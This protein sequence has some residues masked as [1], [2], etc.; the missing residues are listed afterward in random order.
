MGWVYLGAAIVLEVAA[1]LCLKYSESLSRLWPSIAL[2]ILYVLCFLAMIKALEYLQL[3]AMYAVWGGV[4]T[5]LVAL[6]SWW[7]FHDPMSAMKIAGISL[8][9]VGVFMTNL[10]GLANPDRD[11]PPEHPAPAATD[12]PLAGLP[13]PPLST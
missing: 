3:G 8:I 2:F 7:L 10:S 6:F 12:Q 4:G 11:P 13:E 9:V 5:A 1:A